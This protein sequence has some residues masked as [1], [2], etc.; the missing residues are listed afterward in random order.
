MKKVGLFLMKNCIL[1]NRLTVSRL[2]EQLDLTERQMDNILIGNKKIDK[3]ID[4]L[5]CGRFGI[6]EGTF[7]D[8]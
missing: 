2:A 8:V 5:L 6:K 3:N 4:S 1:P 7:L